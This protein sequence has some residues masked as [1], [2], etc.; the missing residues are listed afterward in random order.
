MSLCYQR[1]FYRTVSSKSKFERR[2][3]AEP[4]RTAVSRRLRARTGGHEQA[5]SGAERA[6]GDL[7]SALGGSGRALGEP[8]AVL[9]GL[10]A[11]PGRPCA[12]LGGSGRALGGSGRA[13]GGPRRALCGKHGPVRQNSSICGVRGARGPPSLRKPRRF[14]EFLL[15]DIKQ[16]IYI[17][18]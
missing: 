11:R 4:A 8:G 9:V 17:I 18:C 16:S 1:P 13:L 5:L 3:E 6:H 15:I 2:G 10:W 7:S 12:A 14:F